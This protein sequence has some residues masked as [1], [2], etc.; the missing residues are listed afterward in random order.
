MADLTPEI[1]VYSEV[2]SQSKTHVGI[3]NRIYNLEL[4]EEE[5]EEEVLLSQLPRWFLP[6]LSLPA[7]EAARMNA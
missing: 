7:S 4:S 3:S 5:G 1:W 2:G 6:K